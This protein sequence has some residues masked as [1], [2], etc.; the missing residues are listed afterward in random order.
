MGEIFKLFSL[1]ANSPIILETCLL[2][3][4]LMATVHIL[5]GQEQLTCY[6]K[7]WTFDFFDLWSLNYW[8]EVK[9]RECIQKERFK[10][11]RLSLWKI[12]L[13]VIVSDTQGVLWMHVQK[14][15]NLTFFDLR[16]PH[17]WPE[18]KN[19]WNSFDTIF[20]ELS[21]FFWLLDTINRIWFNGGG[22]AVNPSPPP[23]G[24]GK[25][26]GPAGRGL[27]E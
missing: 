24:R 25:S 16:W 8:P 15:E 5:T 4:F 3:L 1:R 10:R 11:N 19:G 6:L 18:T 12:F 14:S 2:R 22:G 20:D 21:S 7:I 13:A 17:F 9:S 23:S 27:S 26:R